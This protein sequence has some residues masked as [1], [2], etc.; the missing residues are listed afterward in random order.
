[1]ITGW[2]TTTDGT[3]EALLAA[4]GAVVLRRFGQRQDSRTVILGVELGGDRYVVKHASST[5]AE[6]IGWL[7]S[8]IRFHGAVRHEVIPTVLHHLVTADG[9]A[10]VEEWGAGQILVDLYDLAELPRDHPD[11]TYRRFL[12]LA[13][14]ELAGAVAQLIDAH[15][16]VVDA[17]FVAVDLYDGCVLYDFDQRTVRLIDL[18]HYQPGPYVL[19]VDRQ[20]GSTTYMAPEELS[21]GATVDER[22]TVFTLGRMALVYLGC[23]RQGLAT[24]ADFRGSDEQFAVATEACRPEPADRLPT[25]RA[26]QDAWAAATF[27]G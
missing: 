1:M 12:G 25:V 26:L 20:L 8:A 9:L 7:E 13:P 19:D 6:A 24:R 23:A 4:Q 14:D 10:L 27:A 15:V 21:R 5:D 17:G 3:L 2:P 16:A 11:S 18:D 22:T